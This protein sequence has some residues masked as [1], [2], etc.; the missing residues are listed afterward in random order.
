MGALTSLGKQSKTTILAVNPHK[1]HIEFTAAGTIY[2]GQPV[3]LDTAGL[4]TPW[5]KTD[6]LSLLIGYAY[7]QA[8]EKVLV[9]ETVTV[10][11]RGNLLIFAM[12]SGDIDCGPATFSSYDTTTEDTNDNLGYNVY[13]AAGA[14]TANGWILDNP[15][16]AGEVIRV[17]LV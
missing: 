12:A 6:A 7:T 17:L 14:N 4:V 1:L 2:N 5:A 10:I 9:N 15:A 16:A 8:Q 11:T 13:E 3:K